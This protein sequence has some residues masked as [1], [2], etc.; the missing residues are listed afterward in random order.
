MNPGSFSF[1]PVWWAV[2]LAVVAL[3]VVGVMLL[4]LW[5]AGREKAPRTTA[6]A[7]RALGATA[8]PAGA[9]A[10]PVDEAPTPARRRAP[11]KPVGRPA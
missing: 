7:E 6:R 3:T 9:L 5:Q 1:G 10:A 4:F 8:R 11:R 2:F